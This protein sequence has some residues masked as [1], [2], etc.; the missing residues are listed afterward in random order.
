MFGFQSI[1]NMGV[2]LQLMPAKGMTLPFISYGGSSLIAI[3]ISMGMVL[4]L[5]RQ[6]PERRKQPGVLAC[7][8]ARAGR[9]I[10]MAS[11]TI[12]LAAGGTG[13]HL[14]PAEALAHELIARGWTVHLATDDRAERF[15][16]DF[17][18]AADP[19]DRRRRP[20]APATR[21]R[22]LKS[23]WT[24]WQ[25]RAAG[26]GGDPPAMK[27]AAVVGFGGYP[28]LPP[29]Y[30]ATRRSVPTLI[31]EQNAVMGRANRALAGRVSAIAGGF[32]DDGSR[33]PSA[34]R[35]CVTGNPVRPAVV[36]AAEVA[37]RR[38]GGRR[39]VPSAGVRRQPGRP[40]LL[41]GDAGRRSRLLPEEQRA[42]LEDH[43]AGAR[44]TIRPPVEAAYAQWAS[45]PRSRRSSATWRTGS[46]TAHLVI[47]RSGAST[48]SEIAVIGRPALLVP[49]PHA[50][51]HDQAANAAALA[52]AGGAEVHASRRR[53]RPS[54]WPH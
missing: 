38:P 45:R 29:V 36:E 22:L 35:P 49:Y 24:I 53:F 48:V 32:L 54:A 33:A 8:R 51:D 16:G 31:H 15:A 21:S 28:T 41:G 39:A 6:R 9:R 47:S 46:P 3:A 7:R 23:L 30:A 26:L 13:G 1:I 40:V 11:G 14:F 50:L 25:R 10:S 19:S 18:A 4:A 27:P 20:S 44:T 37:Y 52:A 5:T 17:P 34:T 12:L 42:R 43:A 2:N